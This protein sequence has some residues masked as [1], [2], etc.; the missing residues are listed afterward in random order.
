MRGPILYISLQGV[1]LN[2]FLIRGKSKVFVK[3]LEK[4]LKVCSNDII[5]IIICI[6]F[7]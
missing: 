4:Q 1:E 7:E 3:L 2:S 5:L 6:Y